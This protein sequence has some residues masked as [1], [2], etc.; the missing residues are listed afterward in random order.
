M[1]VAP[2]TLT[3]ISVLDDDR[4]YE[5]PL[6]TLYWFGLCSIYRCKLLELFLRDEFHGTAGFSLGGCWLIELLDKW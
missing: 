1:V 4:R 3:T 2:C 5:V 6:I